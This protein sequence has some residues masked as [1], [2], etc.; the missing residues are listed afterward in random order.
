MTR[1]STQGLTVVRSGKRI[2]HDVTVDLGPTGSVAIIG[3]NGAGKSTL[4]RCLAGV[5]APTAGSVLLDGRP[6][7][8]I[9]AVRRAQLLAYMPQQFAP[10]WD[11]LVLEL[12]RIAME[13]VGSIVA[14]DLVE[15][16]LADHHLQGFADRRWSTLSGG[17]RARVA[18]AMA[19]STMPAILLADE[20]SASLDV[21]YSDT[22]IARLVTHAR[23]SL[24]VVVA[25]DMDLAFN[26]F[27]TVLV[28]SEGTVAAAGPA[29][30]IADDVRLDQIFG[31]RFRRIRDGDDII[32]RST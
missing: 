8:D 13:R 12:M 19:L 18:V 3:P 5:D 14:E 16:R 22:V 23:D 21:R 32:L 1:V 9:G 6:I 10:H 27:D 20:P 31:V 25:H 2:L 7:S 15:A 11:L 4:L 26:R 24:V 30:A 28:M 17:E 29:R